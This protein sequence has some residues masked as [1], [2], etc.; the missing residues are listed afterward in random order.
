MSPNTSA[1]RLLTRGLVVTAIA[2][3]SMVI[4][5]SVNAGTATETDVM[6]WL[7][8]V[9]PAIDIDQSNKC[10]AG[11]TDAVAYRNDRIVLRTNAPDTN[12]KSTVNAKLNN[13][14]GTLSVPYVGPIERIT[15][16]N[17]PPANTPVTPVLSVTLLPRPGGA[18][19]DVVGLARRLRNESHVPASPDYAITNSGPYNFYWPHGYPEKIGAITLP[20]TN[21]TPSGQKIGTGIKVGIYDTGLAAPNATDLPTTTQLSADDN[22]LSDIV[23]NGPKMADFPA[24]GHGEAIAGVLT[25]IAPGMTIQEVRINDRTGLATDVSAAR[26]MASSLRTLSRTDYPDLIVNAFG[27]TTCDLDSL[28]PGAMLEPIG[29]EAVVEVVDKFD[30]YQPDGMLIVASA[31]NMATTR[32]HYP[33]AFDSVLGVGALDGNIDGDP[34]P[35]SSPARTAPIADFSNRGSWVDAYAV[36]VDLPTTHT[37]GVRFETGGDI[38]AGKASVDGTSFAAPDIAALIAEKVS[39]SS[40]HLKARQAWNVI[41]ASRIAPLPQCG[42]TKVESGVAIVLSSLSGTA[43]GQPTGPPVSC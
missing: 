4:T 15:F 3:S 7:D 10:M 18:H 41:A 40:P 12:V 6:A 17:T 42:Q 21:L 8:N 27:T 29:L 26:G 39:T 5:A 32:P 19:H 34:S 22:D 25:T 23:S 16:P 20:R 13:M 11:A 43:D 36:G 28:A 14:Y 37:S 31:G 35:W 1:R 2:C 9:S 30:P 33:A 38:L 24:T